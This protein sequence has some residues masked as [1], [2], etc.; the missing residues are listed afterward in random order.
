[1]SEVHLEEYD[2]LRSS[3]F[4]SDRPLPVRGLNIQW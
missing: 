4:G 3:T 1:M 2:H